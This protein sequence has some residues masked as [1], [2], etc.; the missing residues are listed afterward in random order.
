M[1]I[2]ISQLQ[3]FTLAGSGVSIANTT[4]TLSTFQTIDGVNLAM[5]DFGS[6]GYMTLEPGS[7]DREEQISFTGVTQNSNG[8]ATLTGIKTVLFL[9]PYTESTGFSKSHPGGIVV[10]VTNTSGFYNEFAIKQNN[11]TLTGFWQAPDPL[12]A[13]GVATKAYV[14]NL[15][16]GGSVTTNALIEV[17]IAGE[18][19]A[20]GD[21]LYLKAADGRWWKATGATA[22]TVNVIQLGISQGVGTA[23]VNITGGVLRRGVDTHQSGGVAGSIA[24]ISDTSTISTSAG[25]VERAIGNFASATSVTFDPDFY[26]IPTAL[27]K[28]GLAST[29]APASTNLYVTQKDF[30]IGAVIYAADAGSTDD[31][32]ITVTPAPAA[33]VI[34]M[35]FRV[36]I[37]T[38]N[39]GACTLQVNALAAVSIKKNFN[40]DPVTGDFVAGQILELV[41]D[42][43]NFQTLSYDQNHYSN[44]VTTRT[45]ATASGAQTIAHGLGIT[46]KKVTLNAVASDFNPNGAGARVAMSFGNFDAAGQSSISIISTSSLSSNNSATA[47]VV[48]GA[49]GDMQTGV[50]SVDATNITITWTKAGLPTGTAQ[51]TW[52][53]MV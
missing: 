17:G 23:G 24:Y 26:Y 40:Q 45:L 36:K 11:E 20:A 2:K 35:T 44:G 19:V 42:G 18:T 4:M 50:V 28:A 37:N 21:P 49:G 12:A 9:S 6:K 1:A 8:T 47:T 41:Y 30:Q 3:N 31:Y 10:V 16:N 25:T 52:S 27:Q 7:R 53:A 15:V 29:T 48:V 22:A 34:G 46:P 38:A 39:A 13:Q 51:I 5:S 32:V 43:T 33:Y 14:D